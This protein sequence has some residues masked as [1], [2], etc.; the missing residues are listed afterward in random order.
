MKGAPLCAWFLALAASTA[1]AGG[2]YAYLPG[3][4]FH[5]ALL[6][7]GSAYGLVTV[8]PFRMRTEPVTRREF[9][10]FAARQPKWRRDRAAAIYAASG[11]LSDWK[12]S[13]ALGHIDPSQPVVWV[14]WFAAR[15]YCASEGAR[16][17]RWTE[18]EYAAAADAARRDAR[19][20]A[21]WQARTLARLTSRFGDASA[22][23]PHEATNA[24]GLR[25]MHT[26]V[27][28]W[29]DDYA[30]MFLDA[31]ARNPIEPDLL[32]LCGGAAAA[33][34]DRTDYALM[35]R[36][37]TLAALKPADSSGSVGF[38]CVKDDAEKEHS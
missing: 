32:R 2:H 27:A 15:A 4:A 23:S 30:S 33:F 21:G 6:I 25:D 38:R 9:L 7:N 31:D 28:E 12:D 8:A 20:D 13:L 1:V 36:V 17:P 18:W 24:Y 3:G 16:L 37:A 26:Q 22:P 5:S 29:V 35:M 34:A 19:G 14:S 11:Y 10:A